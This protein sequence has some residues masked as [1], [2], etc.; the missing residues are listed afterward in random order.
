MDNLDCIKGGP[1]LCSYT[2]L[3]HS[4]FKWIQKKTANG[5]ESS[6]AINGF[7]LH[8]LKNACH[9][10]NQHLGFSWKLN[11]SPKSTKSRHFQHV[12]HRSEFRNPLTLKGRNAANLTPPQ[13]PILFSV[14]QAVD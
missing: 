8:K 4:T 7:S 13:L 9:S 10:N 12:I 2:I 6:E 5:F 3:P 14:K 11:L 1:T